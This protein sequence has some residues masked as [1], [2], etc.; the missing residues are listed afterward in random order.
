VVGSFPLSIV[1]SSHPPIPLFYPMREGPMSIFPPPAFKV[2]VCGIRSRP[3]CF[4]PSL[5]PDYFSPSSLTGLSHRPTPNPI[6][7]FLPLLSY[8][9]PFFPR[10][11]VCQCEE[12]FT[13]FPRLFLS[14]PVTRFPLFCSPLLFSSEDVECFLFRASFLFF[15][16]L[17]RG[18]YSPFFPTFGLTHVLHFANQPTLTITPMSFVFI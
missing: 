11:P 9:T 15:S 17:S 2:V 1:C 8:S 10:P 18:P 12:N 6:V 7:L 4:F 14:F 16:P 13:C 3:A 5:P